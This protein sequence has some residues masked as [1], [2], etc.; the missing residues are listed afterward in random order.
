MKITRNKLISVIK[1]EIEAHKQELTEMYNRSEA[2]SSDPRE[3]SNIVADAIQ[4]IMQ[5]MPPAE[6]R[7]KILSMS[8][9][10]LLDMAGIPN[11][12]ADAQAA[13]NALG[14]QQRAVAYFEESEKL[15]EIIK[16]E[17][18]KLLKETPTQDQ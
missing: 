5:D 15:S 4:K 8:V 16:E 12:A 10:E 11:T 9:S 13:S 1:E 2:P 3:I 17:L 6:A 18:V 7:A 14:R